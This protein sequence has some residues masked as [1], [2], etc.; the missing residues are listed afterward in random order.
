MSGK[1]SCGP[2]CCTGICASDKVKTPMSKEVRERTGGTKYDKGKLRFDL[3]PARPHAEIARVFTIGANKYGD[4]NWE[5]G[6]DWSR[7]I[8]ALERHLNRWKLGEET[9]PRDGQSHLSS[10][11]WAAMVL[12]EYKFTHPELDDRPKYSPEVLAEM[13]KIF[14]EPA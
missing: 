7:I 13:L 5:K 2:N 9:D 4:R 3:V 8:A 10:I 1:D 14:D 11:A 12:M 6:F